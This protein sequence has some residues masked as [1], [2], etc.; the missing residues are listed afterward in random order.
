MKNIKNHHLYDIWNQVPV[1]YYQQGV[2]RN[3]FQYFWHT[4]KIKLAKSILSN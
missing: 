1:T 3:L 4:H 2:K